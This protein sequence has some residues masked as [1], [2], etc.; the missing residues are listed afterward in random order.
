MQGRWLQPPNMSNFKMTVA[1][2]NGIWAILAS[3]FVSC[4]LAVTIDMSHYELGALVNCF[5][6]AIVTVLAAVLFRVL[7]WLIPHKK[8]RLITV[9]VLCAYLLYV[10]LAFHLEKEYWPLVLW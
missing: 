10:G 8:I 6:P 1:I 9:I 5:W 4:I 3:G 7:C 2:S